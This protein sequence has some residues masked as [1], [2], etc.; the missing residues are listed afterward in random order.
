[1]TNAERFQTALTAAYVDLFETDPQY[2]YVKSTITPEALAVKM[3]AGLTRG[4]ADHNSKGVKR[5]CK[6]CGIKTTLTA[7]MAFLRQI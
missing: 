1:M 4:G 5:A 7:I 6:A 2:A 3:T